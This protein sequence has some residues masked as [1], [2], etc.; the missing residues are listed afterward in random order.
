[1]LARPRVGDALQRA[2]EVVAEFSERGVGGVLLDV[3]DDVE[4]PVIETERPAPNNGF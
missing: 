3:H 2:P 4:A 1:M